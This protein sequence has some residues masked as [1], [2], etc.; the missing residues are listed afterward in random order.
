MAIAYPMSSRDKI[1]A[2]K[3]EDAVGVFETLSAADAGFRASDVDL[4]LIAENIKREDES[5]GGLIAGVRPGVTTELDFSLMLT[6]AATTP[7]WSQV[8]LPACSMPYISS[9]TFTLT[10]DPD[11]KRTITAA[12]YISGTVLVARGMMGTFSI[13]VS[14]G[15]PAVAKFKFVGAYEAEPDNETKPTGVVDTTTIPP[16]F[17]G[18]DALTLDGRADFVVDSVSID[19]GAVVNLREDGN[20]SGG[21]R[22]GWID[23]CRPTITIVPEARDYDDQRWPYYQQA[24]T[25][26]EMSLLIGNTTNNKILI[27]SSSL[28]LSA[29]PSLGDRGGRLTQSLVFDVMDNDL[30]ISFL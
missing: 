29:F 24:G 12:H 26:V 20:C 19:L 13:D 3:L 14:A 15:R 10:N 22:C 2:A 23:V 30:Q 28:N 4:R 6:G 21:Y 1:F 9:R 27:Q 11:R 17:G 7:A 5:T 25:P 8:F 18:E 16:I